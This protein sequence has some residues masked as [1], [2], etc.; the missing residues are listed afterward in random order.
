MKPIVAAQTMRLIEV[1]LEADQGAK[2]RGLLKEL[3]P[4]AEDA[5]RTEEEAFRSHLG[6][7][8]I[9]RE[10]ERELWYSFHWVTRAHFPGRIT[11][12]F[13]RGHLEEP[14]IVA[15]L[16]MIGC[17]VWQF[18]DKGKQ[19]RIQGYKG[20]YGGGMDGV[21]RGIP[22][23]T[24]VNMLAEFKTHNDKSFAK[25]KSDGVRASKFEHYVQ[26]NQYMGYNQLT[27]AIYI[28]VNKND[29]ELYAELVPFDVHNYNSFLKR[30]ADIVDSDDPP[31]RISESP[32]FFKCKFCNQRAV[33]QIGMSPDRNCRTCKWSKPIDN[34]EWVCQNWN[35]IAEAEMQG[36][37]DPII[38]NKEAQLKACN[39]YEKHPSLEPR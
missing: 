27:M 7:S 39:H 5:Y 1:T 21:V 17:E 29:D 8:L 31:P 16:K 6:A 30:A 34:G 4:L 35:M 38:L 25:V 28:A 14:R 13:N 19:F 33:C 24:D 18:D 3:L 32:G 12:L 20:H 9:G 37:E 15:L 10:C 36:W 11:R 2:Y 23:Y 22:E 26:M